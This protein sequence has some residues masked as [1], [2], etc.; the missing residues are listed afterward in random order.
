MAEDPQE[1]QRQV[2]HQ[3]RPVFLTILCILTFT[4]SGLMMM[5]FLN[6]GV[7]YDLSVQLSEI[8][9]TKSPGI[10]NLIRNT[11]PWVFLVG[12]I[13]HA[14]SLL[15]GIFCWH[16]RKIGFHL[17]T[18]AQISLLFLT[19]FFIFPGG[20]PSGDLLFTSSF[21]LLYAL[22]LRIMK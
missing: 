1:L 21:I 6:T 20:L 22:H 17:Y 13:L 10:R 9:D 11:P 8:L 3:R 14:V 16:L 15:G 7:F 4:G 18:I 12:A 19:S 2:V 5:F